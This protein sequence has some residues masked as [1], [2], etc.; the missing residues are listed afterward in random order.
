MAV[1]YNAH[2]ITRIDIINNLIARDGLSTTGKEY[3]MGNL[4]ERLWYLQT[5]LDEDT[6][7]DMIDEYNLLPSDLDYTGMPSI[8]IDEGYLSEVPF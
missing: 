7:H 6:T 2:K 4:Q 3:D 8:K 1:K 5:M